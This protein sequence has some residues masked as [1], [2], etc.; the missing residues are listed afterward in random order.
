M[1]KHISARTIVL[2]LASAILATSFG[3][4]TAAQ[5]ADE[6]ASITVTFRDLDL[7]R[8]A[9]ASVLYERIRAASSRVCGG[10]PDIRVLAQLAAFD[11]CRATAVRQALVEINMPALSTIARDN[12]VEA[13]VASR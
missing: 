4:T 9:D 6:P 8:Q 11:R 12:V 3:G 10:Q 1:T 7:T 5:T 2:G 13:R